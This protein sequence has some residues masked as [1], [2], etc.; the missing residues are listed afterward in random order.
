MALPWGGLQTKGN[1]A[2]TRA[3]AGR[4]HYRL[5]GMLWN[6]CSAYEVP[7]DIPLIA[8]E[9]HVLIEDRGLIVVPHLDL[10]P[11]PKR[12]APFA[13]DVL[14]HRPDGTEEHFSIR[15]LVEHVSLRGGGSKWHIVILIP[16]GTKD[17]V[18]IGSRIIVRAETLMRLNGDEPQDT[19][20]LGTNVT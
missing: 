6:I 18:P 7:P 13:D 17:S 16:L 11:A 10:P 12:F 14:I 1:S 3:N 20:H 19:T 4:L 2:T 9:D 15:F 5:S 8:V